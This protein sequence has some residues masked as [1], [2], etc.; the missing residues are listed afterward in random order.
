MNLQS[1]KASGLRPPRLANAQ[2]TRFRGRSESLPTSDFQSPTLNEWPGWESN[3]QIHEG[4]SFAAFPFAYR[5]G[6][7]RRSA[8]PCSFRLPISNFRLPQAFPTGFE[9][10]ISCVTGRQALQAAPRERVTNE[11]GQMRIAEC[12]DVPPSAFPLPHFLQYPGR[13]S[14]PQTSGSKPDRSSR[15]RTWANSIHHAP[16]DASLHEEREECFTGLR[17]IPP[18][19]GF[20][21][22]HS[23]ASSRRI[24]TLADGTRS[25]PATLCPGQESNLQPRV[26]KP[27]RSSVGVPGRVSSFCIPHSTFHIFRVVLGGLEPPIVSL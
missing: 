13:D 12:V 20:N 14:N 3:P 17:F 16:R 8:A 21:R 18:H 26:F 11:E 15:W 1:P 24:S 7:G 2:P 5:A 10:A 9:P 27:H 23:I 22:G 25:V 4:L 6:R 19:W